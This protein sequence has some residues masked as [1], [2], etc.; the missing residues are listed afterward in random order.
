MIYIDIV[1]VFL[2]LLTST[3]DS[4]VDRTFYPKPCGI[5]AWILLCAQFY[6]YVSSCRKSSER[7]VELMVLDSLTQTTPVQGNNHVV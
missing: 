2:L 6:A 4:G 3:A 1:D 7:L 5:E